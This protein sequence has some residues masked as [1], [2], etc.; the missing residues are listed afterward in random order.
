MKILIDFIPILLFFGAYKLHAF[1]GI[2]KEEA[3]YFATP[4]LMAATILQ[5]AAIYVIDRKLTTLHKFTL[6]L[7]LVF[8][9]ITLAIHDKRYIM[10]KPTVLYVATAI[11]M[12]VG[13]WGFRKN[14]FKTMLGGHLELPDFVWHKL[15][16]AWIFFFLFLAASNAYLV[17]FY[18]EEA[19]IDFKIWG[20]G[21]WIVFFIG[22]G[23]Y[24]MPHIQGDDGDDTAEKKDGS[25]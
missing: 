8:G 2:G 20:Y 19:W 16:I 17:L 12:A 21:F 5:V 22:Q 1:F 14:L 4:V 15:S 10:W 24:L 7:I 13:I 11:A 25:P 18:S 23:V 3:I 6:V 9:S